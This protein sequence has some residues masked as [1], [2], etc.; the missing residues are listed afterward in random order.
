MRRYPTNSPLAAARIVALTMLADGDVSEAELAILDRFSAEEQLGL[1]PREF[2]AVVHALCEDLL[3]TARLSG[4]S[5]CRIDSLTLETLMSEIDDRALRLK[6]VRLCVAV[7]EADNHLADG[8]AT[9]LA[10]AVEHWDLRCELPQ[11]DPA[12]GSPL[13]C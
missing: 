7:A 13:P 4:A 10:A 8:E 6:T 2:C 9:V 1:G 11:P 5:A 3:W 12:Q